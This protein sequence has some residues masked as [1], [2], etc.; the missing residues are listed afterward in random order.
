MF[1]NINNFFSRGIVNGGN[2]IFHVDFYREGS[3]DIP[4]GTPGLYAWYFFPTM[5]NETNF[6]NYS[7]VLNSKTFS[8][9]VSGSFQER[10][11]T[12][13]DS[14]HSLEHCKDMNKIEEVEKAMIAS[15]LLFSNPIYI[16]RSN[17]LGERL[18]EH[19]EQLK[20]ALMATN[21]YD[22]WK[23]NDNDVDTITESKYFGERVS[24]YILEQL[25]GGNDHF[26]N[27]NFV[28]IGIQFKSKN[29]NEEDI[30]QMENFL[31]RTI[32]PVF[33]RK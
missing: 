10:Y 2:E 25:K 30:V 12:T 22:E 13:L 23:L 18:G 4:T 15:C 24:N 26:S 3:F 32:K 9:Y 27:L 20:N 31:N 28:A 11:K 17:D 21:K 8:G 6:E 7:K 5:A 33:G 16:G 1:E 29:I 19:N 14:E